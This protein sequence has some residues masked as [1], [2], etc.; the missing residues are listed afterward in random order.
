MKFLI[1]RIIA[2]VLTLLAV[3]ALCFIAFQI[4]PGDSALLRLGM[5]ATE[6]EIEALR[7]ALGLNRNVFLRFYDWV[8]NAVHWDFGK[9]SQYAMP[10]TELLGSRIRVT[11]LLAVEAIAIILLFSF[12]LGLLT[13]KKENGFLD[14]SI[15]FTGQVFMAIPPFF[16]G[17]ILTLVFGV[18]LHTFVPGSCPKWEDGVGELMLYLFWPALAIAIPKI[19]M[20]VK[21]L[22]SSIFREY[23]KDYVRTAR[24]KGNTEKTVLRKHILKNAIMPVI[25]FTGMMIADILAGSIVVETVFNVPGIGKSLILSIANRD[26]NVVQAIILYIAVLVIVM[27]FIVD[28]LYKAIDPRM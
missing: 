13:A 11:S 27:N 4:I 19:A 9:S 1:R 10:V 5:D 20:V 14:R 15:S 26:F 7:E 28:V 2:L 18:A 12:P 16:L 3:V 23:R 25:T 24:S 21:F 6:E 8:V 22:R 17:V